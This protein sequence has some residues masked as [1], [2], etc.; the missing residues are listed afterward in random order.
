MNAAA[1]AVRLAR[2]LARD[3]TR[4]PAL[5]LRPHARTP[6]EALRALGVVPEARAVEGYERAVAELFPALA[7]RARAA[8]AVEIADKLERP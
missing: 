8:G 2:G 3:R 1:K 4:Y 5:R 7:G 6:D